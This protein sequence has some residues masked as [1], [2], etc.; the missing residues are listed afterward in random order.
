MPHPPVFER[1]ERHSF[2]NSNDLRQGFKPLQNC[3]IV[4]PD[5]TGFG[6][7]SLEVSLLSPKDG[8]T[9]RL[10][11][12]ADLSARGNYIFVRDHP[13]AHQQL[14]SGR[15]TAPASVNLRFEPNVYV[16]T[17]EAV[18]CAIELSNSNPV[19]GSRRIAIRI[20]DAD[21]DS[22]DSE[23]TVTI[24]LAQEDELIALFTS[25]PPAEKR[26]ILGRLTHALLPAKFVPRYHPP[27]VDFDNEGEYLNYAAFEL[28]GLWNA[29]SIGF[30]VELIPLMYPFLAQLEE[31]KV[32]EC[33]D[34]GSRTGAGA[35]LM[36]DLFQSYFSML[37]IDVDSIDIDTT[38][39]DYQIARWAHL[40]RPLVG[41]I[42][43]VE[44]RSYDIVICSHTIEH[45]KDPLPFARR[46]T[47]IAREFVFIYCPFE[48]ID[49]IPGHYR[50]AQHVVDHLE[51]IEQRVLPSWWWRTKANPGMQQ[52]IFF[53]LPGSER[54]G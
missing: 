47:Q 19:V 15:A 23:V 28:D 13:V 43:A 51:P 3:R 14:S 16:D 41:D 11:P 17:V 37:R 29:Q 22:A 44:D 33:L 26:R 9:L 46:L 5:G 25:L 36:A 20:T 45:I 39:H 31:K 6:R 35:A 49:P 18:L 27:N 32:I 2:A 54:R 42:F 8:D 53:V 30:M 21:D 24:N 52:C 10:R 34:V 7:G 12:T 4:N 38:F 40:R 1:I 50:I 48:E